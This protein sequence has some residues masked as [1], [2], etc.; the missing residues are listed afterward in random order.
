MANYSHT[1]Q[2]LSPIQ[3]A[4]AT[5]DSASKD[6]DSST[7]GDAARLERNFPVKLWDLLVSLENE[8]LD[9]IVS[10]APHGRCFIVR[11]QEEFV[12]SIL[13]V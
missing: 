8:G 9:H 2:P 6:V 4:S 3:A 5:A 10:W 13:P 1:T 7:T 12:Q 11:N